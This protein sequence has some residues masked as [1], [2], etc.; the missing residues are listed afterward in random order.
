[1]FSCTGYSRGGGVLLASRTLH[2]LSVLIDA[3]PCTPP[4]KP[5]TL[6]AEVRRDNSSGWRSEG[7]V[8]L[9]LFGDGK[10]CRQLIE[11]TIGLLRLRSMT[12][13]TIR[14]EERP[15]DVFVLIG[16]CREAARHA[17]HD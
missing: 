4:I 3:N 17:Q 15:E 14:L 2:L 7:F 13:N 16:S 8:Q 10:V 1:M 9:G 11:P 5:L 6:G 12:A